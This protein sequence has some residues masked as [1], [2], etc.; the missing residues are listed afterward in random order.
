MK[1][2]FASLLAS[3]AIASAFIACTIDFVRPEAPVLLMRI[4]DF[5]RD[6]NVMAV[7]DVELDRQSPTPAT[8]QVAASLALHSTTDEGNLAGYTFELEEGAS[9]V[10]LRYTFAETVVP[11][12]LDIASAEAGVVYLVGLNF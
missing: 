1:R 11:V 7:T 5:D 4:Q 6:K 3:S 2:L 8:I 9:Y 12:V 10:E